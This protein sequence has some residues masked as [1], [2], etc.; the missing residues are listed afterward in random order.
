MQARAVLVVG[1]ALAACA[2]AACSIF[3]SFDGLPID[4]PPDGGEAVADASD[5][6]PTA[7]AGAACAEGEHRCG[8]DGVVGDPNTL[9]RCLGDG[10][11]AVAIPCT[12]GCARRPGRSGAC[13]CVAGTKYCGND[14]VVGDPSALY[15]CQSDYSGKLLRVCDAGCTVKVNAEDDCR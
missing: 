8:G 4:T 14:Q 12:R 7:E 1:S 2:L 9:Y 11:A 3:T 10:G 13:I 5:E 6:A 15:E